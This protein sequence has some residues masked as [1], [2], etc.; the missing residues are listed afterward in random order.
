MQTNN[1][2]RNILAWRGDIES[3]LYINYLFLIY[4]HD[5]IFYFVDAWSW[6]V[7]YNCKVESIRNYFWRFFF[8]RLHVLLFYMIF[9]S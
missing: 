8:S 3:T 6:L 2:I 9:A 5:S 7:L 1:H 4:I